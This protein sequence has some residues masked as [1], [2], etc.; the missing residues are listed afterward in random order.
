MTDDVREVL[1]VNSVCFNSNSKKVTALDRLRV[2]TNVIFLHE[3]IGAL[4]SRTNLI[5][6]HSGLIDGV[7]LQFLLCRQLL[8]I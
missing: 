1:I 2:R 7:P 4:K 8:T 6:V 5:N 3:N